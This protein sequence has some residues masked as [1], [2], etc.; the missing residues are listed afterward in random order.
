MWTISIH[1]KVVKARRYYDFFGQKSAHF[2]ELGENLRISR[3]KFEKFSEKILFWKI[4]GSKFSNLT[5]GVNKHDFW[6]VWR[7]NI[8][9]WYL[10]C[11]KMII[12]KA[13]F[14]QKCLLEK[15]VT[16]KKQF[17]PYFSVFF[18]HFLP[19]P[20]FYLPFPSHFSPKR[21]FSSPRGGN[22]IYISL[23]FSPPVTCKRTYRVCHKITIEFCVDLTNTLLCLIGI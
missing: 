16:L 5:L 12:F 15:K 21:H 20:F 1:G 2:P 13:F 17:R 7:K 4:Q 18:F 14:Y 22:V 19:S 8:N 11:Q 6:E 23:Q 9:F 10:F 3:R